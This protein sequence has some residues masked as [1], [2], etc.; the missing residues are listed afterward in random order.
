MYG[1]PKRTAGHVKNI[2]EQE[3]NHARA[4]PGLLVLS[5]QPP[6]IAI[7]TDALAETRSC[8]ERVADLMAKATKDYAK[9]EGSAQKLFAQLEK[10]AAD[11]FAESQAQAEAGKIG[12]EA[13]GSP[14]RY[15]QPA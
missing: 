1:Q 11:R 5:L 2:K 3:R 7:T 15:R 14:H 12:G 6:V 9:L 4:L 13:G 10:R 8:E